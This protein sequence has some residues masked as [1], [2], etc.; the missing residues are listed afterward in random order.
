MIFITV[1]G[2]LGSDATTRQVGADSVTSFSV[3]S[4]SKVK[5]EKVTTWVRA[6]VWGK[7]GEALAQYLIKGQSVTIAG[8]GS[9]RSYVNKDGKSVT[10]LEIKVSDVALMGGSKQGANRAPTKQSAAYN[11]DEE[12]PF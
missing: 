11:S 12:I 8:I 4:D 9:L 1:A 5:G 6:Q 10:D 2:K 3:A 7:R